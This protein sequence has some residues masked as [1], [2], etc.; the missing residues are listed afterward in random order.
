MP[1][2]VPETTNL[3]AINAVTELYYAY[4]DLADH[5]LRHTVGHNEVDIFYLRGGLKT[6]LLK[7]HTLAS[8]D[9]VE[10]IDSALPSIESLML[11]STVSK[12]NEAVWQEILN[13]RGDLKVYCDATHSYG[14]EVP[15]E[16]KEVVRQCKELIHSREKRSRSTASVAA[17]DMG[18]ALVTH[19]DHTL[20]INDIEI[21]LE[22]NSVMDL[23]T[24]YVFSKR[25]GTQIE[26]DEIG[27]WLENHP[28]APRTTRNRAIKDACRALN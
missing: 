23:V 26:V 6:L 16:V 12:V 11:V 27:V 1:E 8:A 9:P 17:I 25:K 21:P 22:S 13:A 18:T 24:E 2:Q 14:S 10:A 28:F 15:Q 3:A 5:V 7:Y 20:K 19:E 4:A